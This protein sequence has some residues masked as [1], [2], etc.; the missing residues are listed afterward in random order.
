VGRQRHQ[1]VEARHWQGAEA[2]GVGTGTTRVAGWLAGLVAWMCC[3]SCQAWSGLGPPSPW[4][5]CSAQLPSIACGSGPLTPRWLTMPLV[6]CP[7]LERVRYRERNAT[8]LRPCTSQQ[9]CPYW[10]LLCPAKPRLLGCCRQWRE[11]RAPAPVT[12]AVPQHVTIDA[13][14]RSTRAPRWVARSYPWR[15]ADTPCLCSLALFVPLG[16]KAGSAGL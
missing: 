3:A 9:R 16:G 4:E 10:A 6:A 14:A 1:V 5:H 12:A 7:G 15:V 13:G 8:S 2:G 11:K